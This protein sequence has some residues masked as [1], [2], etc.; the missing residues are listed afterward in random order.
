LSAV[1]EHLG[2]ELSAHFPARPDD[3]N[4][5]PNHVIVEEG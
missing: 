5:L 3:T 1:I 2:K 4:E